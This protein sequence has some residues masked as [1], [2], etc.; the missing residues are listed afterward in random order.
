MNFGQ[1]FSYP[2]QDSDWFKKLIITGLILLIPIVGWLYMLGWMLEIMRRIMNDNPTPLPESVDFGG[3]IGLGFQGFILSLVYS[4]PMIILSL[5]SA[6][7]APAGAMLELDPDTL[8][9]VTMIVSICCGGLSFLYGILLG[10]LLPAA[11]GRFLAAGSL[12]A[13]FKI[14]DVF[15]LVKASFGAYALA[16]LGA[17]VAGLIGE[18]G[19]IVCVVGLLLTLPYSMAIIGNLYGQAYKQATG[20]QGIAV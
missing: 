5:P 17:L 3:Y 9:T 10:L 7:I 15:G 12:G 2:F 20:N 13:G 11:Y 18:L 19:V 16:L 4:I 6:I 8:A 14:G 1:A